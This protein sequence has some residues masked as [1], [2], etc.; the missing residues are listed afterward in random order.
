[1]SRGGAVGM[2]GARRSGLRQAVSQD[3]V[4][5]CSSCRT[6]PACRQA[7]RGR[8]S[9][10]SASG[11]DSSSRPAHGRASP[12]PRQR[13]AYAA[14]NRAAPPAG[15][16]SR[17]R[18]VRCRVAD[19]MSS[20]WTTPASVPSR[21]RRSRD[22]VRRAPKPA[23]PATRE[24]R[25][26]RPRRPGRR[27]QPSRSASTDPGNGRS[28]PGSPRGERRGRYRPVRRRALHVQR[29]QERRQGPGRVLAASDR[30]QSSGDAR[31]PRHDRPQLRETLRRARRCGPGQG[32]AAAGAGR[33]TAAN[34]AP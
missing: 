11:T 34:G 15:G 21:P 5:R 32:S 22:A 30:P 20:K 4:E 17:G 1:M 29:P 27:R 9:G 19:D 26:R 13:A 18:Q 16:S 14:K 28:V 7:G 23:G 2:T 6:R 31:H 8:R 24:P 25:R 12:S 33:A 3:P 10:P